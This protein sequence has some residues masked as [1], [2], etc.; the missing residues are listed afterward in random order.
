[1]IE[2]TMDPTTWITQRSSDGNG[3]IIEYENIDGKRWRITRD[4]NLCGLCEMRPEANTN[5]VLHTNYYVDANNQMQ[6]Y[7][8]ELVWYGEPGTA[9]ACIETNFELR[10]DIPLTPDFT[11][12]TPGCSLVGEWLDDAN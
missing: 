5:V 11:Q 2:E 3:T 9:N 7:T 10:K 12:N 4:C 6:S 8:R 1:M